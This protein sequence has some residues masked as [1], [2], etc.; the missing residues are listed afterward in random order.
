[1][2]KNATRH[3]CI[4]GPNRLQNELIASLLAGQKGFSCQLHADVTGLPPA[5]AADPTL[6]LLDWHAREIQDLFREKKAKGTALCNAYLTALFNVE[7]G[8]GIAER[9]LACGAKGAFFESDPPALF[10]KGIHALF[11]GEV[12]VPRDVLTRCYLNHARPA[13]APG[14]PA[15]LLTG[16]EVE[17]LALLAGGAGNEQIAERLCISTSTV[18][19]HIYNIYKKI[20]VP[21]RLQAALWAANHL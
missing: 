9:A 13:G 21:N 19:T 7:C 8:N 5:P 6:L 12:W 1:M 11:Q 10:I 15:A 17:I 14:T 2:G 20:N 18:K 3:I 16:R 4:V